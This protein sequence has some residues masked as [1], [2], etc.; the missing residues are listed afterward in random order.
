MIEFTQTGLNLTLDT[1]ELVQFSRDTP[2]QV[3][4]KDDTF[5]AADDLSLNFVPEDGRKHAPA[6]VGNN[7]HPYGG[8]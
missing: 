8:Q 7:S 1:D 3:T 2:V 5:A 4:L 6:R